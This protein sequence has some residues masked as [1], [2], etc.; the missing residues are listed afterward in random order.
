MIW[1]EMSRDP[2]HG[3]GAWEFTRSLWSP[4][5]IRKHWNRVGVVPFNA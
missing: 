4:E 2:V 5:A 3:G 1:L